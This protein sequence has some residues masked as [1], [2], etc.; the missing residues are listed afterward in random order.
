MRFPPQ[1]R[2]WSLP[3]LALVLALGLLIGLGQAATAQGPDPNVPHKD[4][5]QLRIPLKEGAD[6]QKQQAEAETDCYPCNYWVTGLRLQKLAADTFQPL[7]GWTFTVYGPN[8]VQVAQGQ[9]GP[10]GLVDFF[11]LPPGTYRVV[12]TPQTN[13]TPY[14][15]A[16]GEVIVPV[17][18]GYVTFFRFYNRQGGIVPP[19]TGTPT[20]TATP[21]GTPPTPPPTQTGALQICKRDVS[22]AASPQP[23][24]G[25]FITLARQGGGPYGTVATQGPD[26]CVTVPNLPAG[27]YRLEELMQPGWE[28]GQVTPDTDGPNNRSTVVGVAVGQTAQVV[29]DNRRTVVQTG[30]TIRACKLEVTTAQ[31]QGRPVSG[32]PMGIRVQP[33]AGGFRFG[34]T[35]YDG[36]VN[37]TNLPAGTYEVEE[38]RIAGWQFVGVEPAYPNPPQGTPQERTLITLTGSATQTVTFRNSRIV[39]ASIKVC[40]I[41]VYGGGETLLNGWQMILRRQDG[42][43]IASG[44]TGTF[45]SGQGCVTFGNLQPGSYQIEEASYFG[46]TFQSVQGPGVT[47]P[48]A[49]RAAI[50]VANGESPTVTFRNTRQ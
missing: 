22:N 49:G 23:V 9:T 48:A 44:L 45:Y 31:P 2:R 11:N 40:K 8:N 25:W 10:N 1:F 28:F 30:A 29:F 13:W 19:G 12:E 4:P 37:F 50:T 17:Y 47:S 39:P 27:N 32:W 36:C 43:P 34:Y 20:V 26:G 24:A 5:E 18:G 16:S 3:L 15:P 41:G 33:A 6:A 14:Y 42:T 35:G 7:A 46:W 21:T 38:S